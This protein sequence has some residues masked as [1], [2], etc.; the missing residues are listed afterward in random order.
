MSSPGR[1][2]EGLLPPSR[3][4]LLETTKH[5]RFGEEGGNAVPRPQNQQKLDSLHIH[6]HPHHHVFAFG[7]SAISR[8]RFLANC[9]ICAQEG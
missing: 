5:N 9:C 4:L 7:S 2:A 3:F 8:G 1:A 6:T